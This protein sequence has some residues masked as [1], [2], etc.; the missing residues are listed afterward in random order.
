MGKKFAPMTIYLDDSVHSKCTDKIYSVYLKCNLTFY[1]MANYIKVKIK[2]NF[3]VIVISL[4][5]WTH[6][7]QFVNLFFTP[8]SETAKLIL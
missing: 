8:K 6:T 1:K 7:S 2:C 5:T 4:D 3:D